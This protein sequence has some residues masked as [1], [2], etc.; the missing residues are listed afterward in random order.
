MNEHDYIKN[1]RVYVLSLISS[2]DEHAIV[3]QDSMIIYRKYMKYILNV[4]FSAP[5]LLTIMHKEEQT[6]KC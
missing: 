3:Q 2:H 5:I 1:L 6:H 4:F